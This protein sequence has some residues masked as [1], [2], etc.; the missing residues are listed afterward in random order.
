MT[1]VRDGAERDRGGQEETVETGVDWPVVVFGGAPEPEVRGELS[2]GGLPGNKVALT[3]DDGPDQ[4]TD[5]ILD[6][7]AD[8]GVKATF[9][10][11]GEKVTADN[12]RRICDDGHEIGNHTWS[13]P[14]LP[15]LSNEE[16]VRE[17]ADCSQAILAAA[18][19]APYFYR[20]PFL[21][22]P[23]AAKLAGLA[24]GM[25]SVSADVIGGD[26][27]TKEWRKTAT[28]VIRGVKAGGRIVLLHDGVPADRK[29]SRAPTVKAV[30]AIVPWL[31]DHGYELVT[32]S[33][34]M[35]R[36]VTSDA[37]GRMVSTA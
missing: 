26:W 11:I 29:G 31:K 4:W 33:E 2:D 34:L 19:N 9:F 23:A 28:H 37:D 17:L 21:N 20:A 22:D 24:L 15:V 30:K 13:H 12:V 5:P 25:V 36:V 8:E 35:G 32:V 14:L 7:L 10:V 3:F 6:V 18:G 1:D 16:I 27:A